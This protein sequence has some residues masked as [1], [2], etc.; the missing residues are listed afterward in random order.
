[1]S[2]RNGDLKILDWATRQV[3]KEG[4]LNPEQRGPVELVGLM[5]QGRILVM[6]GADDKACLFD[7]VEWQAKAVWDIPRARSRWVSAPVLSP[8]ERFLLSVGSNATIN[9]MDLR[10]GETEAIA[11]G[12]EWGVLDM[13]FLP[14]SR[15]FA[16]SSGE[17]T[18]SLWDMASRGVIDVL[19]GHLLG[20]HAV[21]ISPDGQRLVSGSKGNEAVKL[22][23]INTRHEVATLA[24]EGLLSRHL[25]FAPDGRL[26]G[27]INTKD[28]AHIWR[29]PSLPE[30]AHAEEIEDHDRM[31]PETINSQRSGP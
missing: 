5:D 2:T 8:D 27:A 17:G 24:G 7:T 28:K 10:N 31:S 20:V 29:A 19:R 30:I 3:I 16:T 26:L 23:D 18:V 6:L 14:D 9:F 1:M 13:A 12:Q 22:W 15:I 11:T 25:K 21:A 4:V